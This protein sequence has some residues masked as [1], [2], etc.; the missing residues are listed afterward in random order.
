MSSGSE[1]L[2]G[3][4][5]PPLQLVTPLT[6]ALNQSTACSDNETCLLAKT[7]LGGWSTFLL[8]KLLFFLLFYFLVIL[9]FI[10]RKS[11]TFERL[12]PNANVDFIRRGCWCCSAQ[13]LVE[14]GH[15]ISQFWKVV[16][17][18]YFGESRCQSHPIL[19]PRPAA[20]EEAMLDW[21]A[22]GLV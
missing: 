3:T 5:S 2:V 22:S 13:R 9:S 14:W 21:L 19:L 15:A 8:I 12:L 17:G 6:S 20:V 7:S 18:S 16:F 10:R 1:A 4:P 11:H